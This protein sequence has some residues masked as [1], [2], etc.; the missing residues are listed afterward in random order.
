MADELNLFFHARNYGLDCYQGMVKA[1]G[2]VEP[3]PI[4]IVEYVPNQTPLTAM[5]GSVE[6]ALRLVDDLPVS[7]DLRRALR[8]AALE[9]LTGVRLAVEGD[10]T[11][12]WVLLAS[13]RASERCAGMVNLAYRIIRNS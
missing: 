8:T 7:E 5:I 2:S 10:D 1:F 4:E 12:E 11:P 13:L 6:I 3:L 9:W